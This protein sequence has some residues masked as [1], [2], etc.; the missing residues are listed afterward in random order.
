MVPS[1][2][3]IHG[4]LGVAVGMT[5]PAGQPQ[6]IGGEDQGVVVGVGEDQPPAGAEDPCGLGDPGIRVGQALQHVVAGTIGRGV[7]SRQRVLE[8][9]LDGRPEGVS[10]GQ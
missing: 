7:D 9:G 10:P 5:T 4:R 6:V 3:S 8:V 1:T 2:A